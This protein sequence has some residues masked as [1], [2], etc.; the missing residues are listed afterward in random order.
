M[1]R[2]KGKQA[3]AAKI[4]EKSHFHGKEERNAVTG[5]S[6]VD[7]P[8]DKKKENEYCYLPKKWIHTWSGH[9]KGVNAIRFFP[10]SGVQGLLLLLLKVGAPILE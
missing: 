4:Q 8:K 1:Q 5:R 3:A 9:T 6:W 2:R 10:G 7:P